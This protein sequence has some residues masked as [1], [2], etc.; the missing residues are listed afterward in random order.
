MVNIYI[1]Q[2]EDNKYYIGKTTQPEIRL[3]SHFN[4][5][6]SSW[7]KKYKPI[8]V[9]GL[10]PDCDNYDEDK[11]TIKYMEKHGINNVRGGSF[12][13]FNLSEENITTIKRMINGVSDNCYMCGSKD[14]FIKDCKMKSDNIKEIPYENIEPKINTTVINDKLGNEK[15]DC[16]SSFLKPHR[17]KKCLINNI[18]QPPNKTIIPSEKQDIVQPPNKIISSLPEEQVIVQTISSPEKQEIV[19]PPNI[20]INIIQSDNKICERCGRNGHLS[21]DCFANKHNNGKTIP[22]IKVFYCSNCNKEFDTQ[23]GATCHENLYCKQKKKSINKEPNN[24]C[25]RCGRE[26]HYSNDC[27]ASKHVN[28]KCLH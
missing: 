26:G 16:I 14:H 20:I 11:Y 21:N 23:K 13:E 3:D 27:Y 9:I 17:R 7:T 18:I 19:Q 12:C 25:Y 1:L 2:L 6:G 15:C 8:K 28:G 22:D 24:N 5:N 4:S 10:I